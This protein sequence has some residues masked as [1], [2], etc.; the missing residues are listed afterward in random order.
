[1]H[2]ISQYSFSHVSTD[3][4]NHLQ[5]HFAAHF[6]LYELIQ[7]HKTSPTSEELD[8][9]QGKTV[10]DGNVARKYLEDL[11]RIDNN[12][13]D[14]FEKQSAAA[15]VYF[16]IDPH[17]ETHQPLLLRNHG[18][19]S[20]LKSFLQSLLQPPTSPSLSP[21][22]RNS[23]PSSSTHTTQQRRSYRSPTPKRFDL[24]LWTLERT[25][26]RASRQHLQ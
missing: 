15:E 8:I 17:F 6:R 14:M 23:A 19:R 7:R 21:M 2:Y 4:K 20:I 3:L 26:L 16:H 18:I 22:A 1:M 25:S 12:I 11:E 13:R 5:R 24:A 9:M 10:L